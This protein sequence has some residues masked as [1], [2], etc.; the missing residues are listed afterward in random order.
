[1]KH[2]AKDKKRKQDQVEYT[3]Q[4]SQEAT[5]RLGYGA[6]MKV[7]W[8]A[9]WLKGVVIG[10][11]PEGITVKY[12]DG[13]RVHADLH[14]RGCRIKVFKRRIDLDERYKQDPF[15][16]C[17]FGQKDDE[18]VCYRCREEKWPRLY[19]L[20][21]LTDSQI[22]EIESI[23]PSQRR[24]W[25]KNHVIG[26]HLFAN[27]ENVENDGRSD[28][29]GRGIAAQGD[30]D[31]EGQD[32]DQEAAREQAPLLELAVQQNRQAASGHRLGLRSGAHLES[33][34]REQRHDADEKNFSC[35]S[36]LLNRLIN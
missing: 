21:E 35:K 25:A 29:S 3:E 34:A 18:C 23:S 12:G 24:E 14:T 10:R 9:K 1:M 22:E 2:N 27:S 8:A 31:E 7:K 16:K 13:I 19:G 26:E 32:A 5:D 36:F 4:F 6:T 15:L 20:W 28:E 11:E 30:E 33:Q 17:P